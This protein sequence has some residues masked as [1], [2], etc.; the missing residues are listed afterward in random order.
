MTK[1]LHEHQLGEEFDDYLLI[2]SV[3]K[4]LTAQQSPFLSLTLADKSGT[5]SAKLWSVTDEQIK[6]FAQNTVV[7]ITGII[8]DYRGMRQL[9]LNNIRVATDDEMPDMNTLIES[10]PVSELVLRDTI[11]ETID[12][13]TNKD[14]RMIT[15]TF[16]GRYHNDLYEYP[17]ASKN[18]HA[19]RSGLAH[20]ICGMLELGEALCKIHPEANRDLLLAGIILHDIGK[21]HEYESVT[22]PSFTLE[23]A[24][25]GHISIMSAELSEVAKT[26]QIESE[27]VLLLQHLVLSHHSKG[28]WGSP[29]APQILEAELLHYIDMLDAKMNTL[30]T[31]LAKTEDGAYTERLYALDNRAFYKH[32]LS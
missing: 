2:K 21:I 13:L 10:A 12:S 20:H 16:A 4:G 17:A 7:H 29:K 27:A 32:T 23:G 24:L 19:Y 14:I 15:A 1:T 11:K 8:G 18:H 31:A 25:M 22:D 30:K 26:L 5:I 28:E 6:T 9:N 3:A